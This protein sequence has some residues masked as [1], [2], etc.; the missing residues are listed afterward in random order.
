MKKNKY[1]T[2]AAAVLAI[3]AGSM[4]VSAK[5]VSD[6]TDVQPAHWYYD[7]VADVSEKELMTGLSY[8]YFGA[9]ECL[10]RAQVATILYRMHDT[11]YVEYSPV[12]PDV[13]SEQ[14]FTSAV[15]WANENGIITGYT[16]TGTFAP[17]KNITREELA[18]MMWRNEGKPAADS[19]Q[20]SSF[21][22]QDLVSGYAYEA[23][24]W[25]TETGIIKGMG[26]DG[27]LNPQ[28]EVTRAECAAILSRSLSA[29][30]HIWKDLG[31]KSLSWDSVPQEDTGATSSVETVTSINTCRTCGFFLGRDAG[32]S[33]FIDRYFNHL[34]NSSC[35]GS[36]TVVS[37][38]AHYHLYECYGCGIYKRGELAYYDYPTWPDGNFNL[39]PNHLKLTDDQIQELGLPL[40]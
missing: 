10:A 25:A 3:S 4:S 16:D 36:Y 29:H 11:P 1:L 39:T 32:S 17:S 28:G 19:G 40:P 5:S 6:Y 31:V 13:P 26:T 7:Y 35:M 20:F 27:R 37:V 18:V 21:P 14:F 12:F 23:M 24:C 22:D 30:Q 2:V 38:N 8:D 9:S 15:L 33:L 34:E